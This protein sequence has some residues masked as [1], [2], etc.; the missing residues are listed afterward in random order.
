MSLLLL[1]RLILHLQVSTASQYPP[2]SV[3]KI[4]DLE[5]PTAHSQFLHPGSTTIQVYLFYFLLWVCLSMLSWEI[6]FRTLHLNGQKF[7]IS[8]PR[9]SLCYLRL[10]QLAFLFYLSTVFNL[11]T[12]QHLLQYTISLPRWSLC[13]LRLLQLAFLFHG[14]YRV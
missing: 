5:A 8:L 7:S 3:F 10:I 9:W 13:Y 11:V 2:S 14:F 4:C 6:L 1:C 12:L